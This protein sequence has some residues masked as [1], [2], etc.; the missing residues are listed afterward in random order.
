LKPFDF[1]KA[2]KSMRE[3]D[4]MS[5]IQFPDV[6]QDY[7][8]HFEKFGN[9]TRLP[10]REFLAPMDVGKKT[11]FTTFGTTYDV[12]FTDV[13]PVVDGV[14][15]VSF[16]VNGQTQTISVKPKNPVAVPYVLRKKGQEAATSSGPTKKKAEP[17]VPSHVGSPLSG[18]VTKIFGEKGKSFE[19]GAP[20]I[21]LSAMKMEITVVA[22]SKGVIKDLYVKQGDTVQTADLLFELS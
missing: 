13:S 20:V 16:L 6:Y 15:K 21:I 3:V 18:T 9:V 17:S 7:K 2:D 1:D 8:K 12:T 22:P 14:S 4:V 10:T 19:K 5:E 11:Q